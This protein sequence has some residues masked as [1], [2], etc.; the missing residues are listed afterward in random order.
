MRA[1]IKSELDTVHESNIEWNNI[2]SNILERH[3][4]KF[5]YMANTIKGLSL[6]LPDD[7]ASDQNITQSS[8]DGSNRNFLKM[9]WNQHLIDRTTDSELMAIDEDVYENGVSDPIVAGQFCCE[10]RIQ[11][12]VTNDIT[13]I[14]ANGE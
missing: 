13:G 10:V 1:N 5:K 11:N 14:D 4:L 7:E 8:V 3:I 2:L 12:V 6:F 9:L